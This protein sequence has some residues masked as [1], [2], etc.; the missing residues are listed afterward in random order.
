MSRSFKTT[1]W[2][3]WQDSSR[4]QAL[5][6]RQGL[7]HVTW[8]LHSNRIPFCYL[9]SHKLSSLVCAAISPTSPPESPEAF[10]FPYYHQQMFQ[11]HSGFGSCLKVFFCAWPLIFSC[12]ISIIL[13]NF[14]FAS[15]AH[16]P[17][18]FNAM[19][20][21]ISKLTNSGIQFKNNDKLPTSRYKR[22]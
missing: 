21:S 9:F 22:I 13:D 11:T 7:E 15:A 5:S 8:G 12:F 1:L 18:L 14:S 6:I 20:C 10:T 2:K 3:L 19:K 4:V 17:I 16:M